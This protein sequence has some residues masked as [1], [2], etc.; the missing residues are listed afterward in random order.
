MKKAFAIALSAVLAIG[1]T[2]CGGGQTTTREDT[3]APAAA[4]VRA[5]TATNPQ[6][7]LIFAMVI[8][9]FH[10]MSKIALLDYSFSNVS[11]VILLSEKEKKNIK[12]VA[13]Q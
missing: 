7:L 10:I 5:P 11:I 9:S 1:V 6:Y 12:E 3:N 8:Y 13:W 2:A 4:A